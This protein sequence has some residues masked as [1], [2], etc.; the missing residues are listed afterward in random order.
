MS[1]LVDLRTAAARVG[2]TPRQLLARIRRGQL[3]TSKPPGAREHR[4]AIED[5]ERIFAPTL[6]STPSRPRRESE[7][8][9][10]DRQLAAAGIA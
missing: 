7:K 10:I 9:R 2:R 6:R 8:A 1:V 3:P 4:V 5:V